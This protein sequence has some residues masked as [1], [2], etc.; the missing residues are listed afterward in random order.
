MCAL[1]CVRIIRNT[2]F[3]EA[4]IPRIPARLR[5]SNPSAAV[6]AAASGHHHPPH[7]HTVGDKHVFLLFAITPIYSGAD[8][9]F[10]SDF[11]VCRQCSTRSGGRLSSSLT[12]EAISVRGFAEGFRKQFGYNPSIPER[13]TVYGG[14]SEAPQ[15]QYCE[16]NPRTSAER[17]SVLFC[18]F[19]RKS[20]L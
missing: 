8:T 3:E 20:S 12:L 10:S 9:A 13:L 18:I 11:T 7:H 2:F 15:L 14:M 6:A 1:Q 16:D 19:L 4:V 17:D 5:L